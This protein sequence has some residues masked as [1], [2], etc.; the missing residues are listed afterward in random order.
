MNLDWRYGDEKM[1]LRASAFYCL[2]HHLEEH[3]RS[4]YEFCSDWVSQGNKNVDNIEQH[5]QNYLSEINEK[6]ID[7]LEQCFDDGT[8]FNV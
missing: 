7:H 3:C 2:S 5:F 1:Q 4:V 6:N 8:D